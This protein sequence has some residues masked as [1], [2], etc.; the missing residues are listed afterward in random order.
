[1]TKEKP[2]YYAIIPAN[3]RYDNRLSDSEKML[4]GEITALSNK[5]GECWASNKYFAELYDKS[6]VTISRRISRLESF[7]YIK[8]RLVYRENSKEIEKRVLTILN[9]PIINSDSTP[10]IKNDNT[11]II[12]NDK[13]NITRIN[14][15]SNNNTLAS[16]KSDFE[17]LWALYPNKKNKSGAFKAYKRA[18]KEGTTNKQIQDGIIA[19]KK[20][21]ADKHIKPEYIR[22]GSTWFNQY[23][24][25]DEY[26]IQNIVNND[27]SDEFEETQRKLRE[28]YE[29]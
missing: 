19:Y 3:V 8:K 28:A 18:I 15:T 24:W 22:H 4:Y 20:E 27:R 5:T 21:I 2:S 1:M 12:K 16:Q 9:T 23:G 25:E 14:T 13:D 6:V 7:G 17:K 10:I 11:P 29:Q 26:E